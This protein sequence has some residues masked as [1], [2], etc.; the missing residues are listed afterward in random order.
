M[1]GL[2]VSIRGTASLLPGRVVSTAELGQAAL[3]GRDPADL[4]ARTGIRTRHWADR[5]ATLAQMAADTLGRA[6]DDAGMKPEAL[7]RIIV[8]NCT[9][10]ELAFPGSAN[11]VADL[12]GIS[13]CC[14]T[15]DVNNACMG[16][17][18]ILDLAARS[19]A[20]GVGPVGVVAIEL[21]SRHVR[22]EDPRPYM[23]FADG[24]GAAVVD[25]SRG[26]SRILAS[27]LAN[28]GA[29]GGNAIL[30]N[31]SLTRRPEFIEFPR[32]HAHMTEI[33]LA[34]VRAA[35]DAV[36]AQAN[37]RIEDMDWVLPHQPNGSMYERIIQELGVDP[38]R[39]VKIV[40]AVGSVGSA[41][42][43]ISLDRLR[44]TRGW[45]PGQHVLMVGVGSG[46]SYGAT[47][48]RVGT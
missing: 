5:D 31:P 6:L 17:L 38:A 23:V 1:R 30:A 44:R 10:A 13:G 12:L 11:Q 45:M 34:K 9:G 32:T 35:T 15:F 33:A 40:D 26:G 2:P 22:A 28:D 43:P 19:V 4:E 18:T 16:F 24:A 48:Y 36:L 39:T 21:C 47:L 41:S 8:A 37:L 29:L 27:H 20:T 3:P 42:I 14:D 7:R 46:V 25:A